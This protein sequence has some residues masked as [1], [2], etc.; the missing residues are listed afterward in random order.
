MAFYTNTPGSQGK[1]ATREAARDKNR[2]NKISASAAMGSPAQAP[3]QRPARA[4]M[5]T[6]PNETEMMRNR[7]RMGGAG[8][9]GPPAGAGTPRV[10]QRGS[11][12]V[13]PDYGRGKKEGSSMLDDALAAVEAMP[14]GK[15]GFK[16]SAGKAR[17]QTRQIQKAELMAKILGGAYDTERKEQGST[18]RLE[19]QQAGRTAREAMSQAG[20]TG[21]T[22][23]REEGEDSR[24][25]QRNKNV[26]DQQSQQAGFQATAADIQGQR[27]MASADLLN[28][29]KVTAANRQAGLDLVKLGV[30]GDKAQQVS[31]AGQWDPDYSGVN[32]PQKQE[33]APE[34][35]W[36][37]PQ[38]DNDNKQRPGTG[39]YA[40]LPS[41]QGA[42]VNE[43]DVLVAQEMLGRNFDPS[44]MDESQTKYIQSLRDR[45]DDTL[46]DA[47]MGGAM[48]AP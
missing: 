13:S 33:K 2:K 38:F 9:A 4:T 22:G 18:G 48:L 10:V 41:T 40:P 29:Q 3:A 20:E 27:T 16:G 1:F 15:G 14:T 45:G 44:N 19:T 8:P 6:L 11:G 42:A 21:R 30:P 28:Q 36:I 5:S 43:G 24:L 37:P 25:A 39:I 17:S 12:P 34:P 31:A 26:L 7:F 35:Q 46:A 47:L 23:M 32:V